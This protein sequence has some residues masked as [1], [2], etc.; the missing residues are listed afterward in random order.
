MLLCAVHLLS[1]SFT[2][3]CCAA[4]YADIP[5]YTRAIPRTLLLKFYRQTC[6][7]RI[8]SQKQQNSQSEYVYVILC[9]QVSRASTQSFAQYLLT[10]QHRQHPVTCRKTPNSASRSFHHFFSLHISIP[11]RR[12]AFGPLAFYL[13]L[14]DKPIMTSIKIPWS[15]STCLF[16]SN[17]CS[18]R[19]LYLQH[20]SNPHLLLGR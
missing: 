5:T 3:F 1:Q 12:D 11:S 13:S 14:F 4:V 8:L 2:K 6:H 16:I 10:C 15:I 19:H 17:S 9:N 7:I 18:A 20:H